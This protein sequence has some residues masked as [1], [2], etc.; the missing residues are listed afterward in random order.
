M[1]LYKYRDFYNSKFLI[2]ILKHERIYLSY[3]YQ[4]VDFFE[5]R[6]NLISKSKKYSYGIVHLDNYVVASFSK[7]WNSAPMWDKYANGFKGV[8]IEIE[9]DEK[10]Y[11][12]GEVI[13]NN[14]EVSMI[15]DEDNPN[16]YDGMFPLYSKEDI[17]IES[18]LTKK[19]DWSFEREVRVFEKFDHEILLPDYYGRI[20]K[21]DSTGKF[22]KYH[23]PKHYVNGKITKIILGP[24]IR[25][26]HFK[27]VVEL[28]KNKK[29][30]VYFISPNLF[31]GRFTLSKVDFKTSI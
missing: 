4:F 30:P 28:V 25:D 22:K 8:C 27:M 21:S 7:K 18:I 31:N 29:I 16:Q 3:S 23:N 14:K 5:L 17:P 13:Y 20:W 26:K 11:R 15:I 24:K 10:E 12:I 19:K 1:K 2:D 6:T 9:I